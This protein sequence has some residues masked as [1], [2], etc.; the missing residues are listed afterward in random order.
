[1][2]DILDKN[3]TANLLAKWGPVLDAG[4]PIV[5]ESV[6][7]STA[8]VLENTERDFKMKGQMGRVNEAEAG[9]IDQGSGGITGGSSPV[10]PSAN[11]VL[12]VSDFHWPSIVI[13]MVRRIF[14]ALISNEIVGVQPMSGPVGFAFA[15]RARYG[16]NGSLGAGD[17]DLGTGATTN[18]PSSTGTEIGYN[19]VDTRY[20]G[21]S[22]TDTSGYDQSDYWT[23][24]TGASPR[25]TDGEGV[26]TGLG[27][28]ATGNNTYPMARFELLKAA[29][30]AKTRKLGANWSPELAEDMQAMHG[31]DVESEMINMITYEIAA[32][33]DRQ[34][35]N[36]QVKAA[37]T[38]D[39][40]STWTPVSADGR[41][42]IERIGT[43]LTHLNIKSN[44]IAE[45]TR[46]GAA[47]YCI[48][49]TR[50]T[51][52]LQRLNAEAFTPSNKGSIPS[53][54]NSGVGALIKVGMINAGA[55]LMIRDTFAQ[56]DYALL[57]YK[58]DHR[59]DAGVIYC[60]YIPVQMMKDVNY[61]NFT[62]VLGARTR[63]GVLNSVW[64]SSNYFQFVSCAG[65]TSVGLANE[66]GTFGGRVFTA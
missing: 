54:P 58:G 66:Y 45:S 43:L 51:S 31:I 22:A 16:A 34:L 55:Q 38:G 61:T 28:Y 57:G 50:V 21:T 8:M 32:E 40:T 1:M 14:P 39:K 46:R 27:E 26:H 49:S 24:Y 36:E 3:V 29:V 60:P 17:L 19:M 13:P 42:Q 37:I 23:A 35:L 11:G 15:F 64:G 9:M 25:F 10:N 48:A 33:I 53:L 56:G 47:N 12:G 4:A 18:P 62:P 65:M 20:T 2:N 52:L 5:S 30:E 7:I 59:G 44:Q 6:R 63:Y 41:N